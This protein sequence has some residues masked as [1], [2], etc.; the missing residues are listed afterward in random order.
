VP[1][2]SGEHEKPLAAEIGDGDAAMVRSLSPAGDVDGVVVA[3]VADAPHPTA[4]KDRPNTIRLRLPNMLVLLRE[5]SARH[6]SVQ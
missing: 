2:D 5:A 6:L 4:R 3:T 1:P